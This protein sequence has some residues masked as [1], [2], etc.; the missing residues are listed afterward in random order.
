MRVRNEQEFVSPKEIAH[1]LKVSEKTVRKWLKKKK[2]TEYKI[3]KRILYDWQEVIR[4]M[5]KK[6]AEMKIPRPFRSR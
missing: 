2:V 3:G 1:R 5:K 4:I 6:E